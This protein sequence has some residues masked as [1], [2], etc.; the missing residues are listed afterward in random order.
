MGIRYLRSKWLK[1]KAINGD[2]LVNIHIPETKRYTKDVLRDMLSKHGMVYI[3]PESGSLGIGV[4]KVERIRGIK[5]GEWTYSYQKG[6]RKKQFQTFGAM[7]DSIEKDK[8]PKKYLVQKGIRTLKYNKRSFDMRIMVQ[9]DRSG[10][11]KVTGTVCRL[12]APGR[13]VSNGSQGATLHTLK[14]MLSPY[15]D[16]AQ[17]AAVTSRLER[18]SIRV[19][20]QYARNYRFTRE[21]GL[22]I[23]LDARLY[24]WILEVNTTPQ[25]APF[26]N[27]DVP[28]YNRIKA[29]RKIK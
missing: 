19:A 17:L 9:R 26:K 2:S 6:R 14:Q 16:G 21:L 10:I 23:A 27:I 11:W 28:M 7:Y 8:A 29:F 15:A 4:M 25:I 20:K 12:S 13:I 18:L 24:P 3:K 22:D 5:P 1:T